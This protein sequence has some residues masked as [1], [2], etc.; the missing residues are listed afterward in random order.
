MGGG[1]GPLLSDWG[2][3]ECLQCGISGLSVLR[4]HDISLPGRTITG[5]LPPPP[6]TNNNNIVLKI[7][8]SDY[9]YHYRVFCA[10]KAGRL[11][12]GAG[13]GARWRFIKRF[14]IIDRWT[15]LWT[16]LVERCERQDMTKVKNEVD[17]V[18]TLSLSLS[19]LSLPD[20]KGIPWCPDVSLSPRWSKEIR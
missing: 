12:G 13:A 3:L 7:S 14:W 18:D 16:L 6:S 10:C 17:V 4:Q 11:G 20:M 19:L 1:F 9:I 8:L 2:E 5:N 15:W